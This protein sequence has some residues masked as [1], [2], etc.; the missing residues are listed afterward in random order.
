MSRPT[1]NEKLIEFE[2]MLHASVQ[3]VGRA[4]RNLEQ[5]MGG[6]SPR[7]PASGTPGGGKG[8]GPTVFIKDP[9]DA[10][11]EGEHVPTT[12]VEMQAL[13]GS[14]DHA[15]AKLAELR[16]AA[17]DVV[18]GLGRACTSAGVD[19]GP[20]FDSVVTTWRIVLLA[21]ARARRLQTFGPGDRPE[22]W[23][24]L[25]DI[26]RNVDRVYK[27]CQAWG[28]EPGEPVVSKDR[29][30]LLAVDLTDQW[31]TSHL[32]VGDKRN[33]DRGE[34]CQ[35][36]RKFRDVEGFV[37]PVELVR[38]HVD[39]RR[40]YDHQIAPFRQAHRDRMRNLVAQ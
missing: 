26:D 5:E 14:R 21:Y 2:S 24:A 12:S 38:I 13:F 25:D 32:R 6:F 19:P 4:I 1:V 17:V 33:R 8:G 22:V 29:A 35:W 34:L 28:Y 37:P 30:E 39:D 18:H 15:G 23:S 11:D 27:L 3:R 10:D 31:C 7:T 16:L 40:V 20:N 36:C 9:R